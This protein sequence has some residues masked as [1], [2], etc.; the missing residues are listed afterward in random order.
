MVRFLAA[1]ARPF[2]WER[3]SAGALSPRL[4][5][6]GPSYPAYCA[7]AGVFLISSPHRR[8]PASCTGSPSGTVPLTFS[9]HNPAFHS[10]PLF[11]RGTRP[12]HSF[13]APRRRTLWP[14]TIVESGCRN[15]SFLPPCALN[16]RVDQHVF[17]LP[18]AALAGLRHPSEWSCSPPWE[19]PGTWK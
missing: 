5:A 12:L 13:T 2:L 10:L 4:R 11:L 3:C 1:P 7:G 16:A 8:F 15:P 17:F 14:A 9:I 6:A 19:L 18:S